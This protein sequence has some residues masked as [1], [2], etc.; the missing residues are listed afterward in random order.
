MHSRQLF[1]SAPLLWL[2]AVALLPSCAPQNSLCRHSEGLVRRAAKT[3]DPDSS[4]AMLIA[5]LSLD[6]NCGA[7][8]DKFEEKLAY[9]NERG[10]PEK[11]LAYTDSAVKYRWSTRKMHRFRGEMLVDL[12]KFKRAL[13]ELDTALQMRYPSLGF[14]QTGDWKYSD[15]PCIYMNRAMCKFFLE[16][17]NGAREDAAKAIDLDR[18][19]D[20]SLCNVTEK[21]RALRV[22]AA[23]ACTPLTKHLFRMALEDIDSLKAGPSHI[24]DRDEM[25]LVEGYALTFLEEYDQ[26]LAEIA[27]WPGEMKTP[28]YAMLSYLARFGSL[29]AR[30]EY[31]SLLTLADSADH[32]TSLSEDELKKSTLYEV[33]FSQGQFLKAAQVYGSLLDSTGPLK[34]LSKAFN[35][36][37]RALALSRTDSIAAARRLIDTAL[38]IDSLEPEVLLTGAEVCIAGKEYRRAQTLIDLVRRIDPDEDGADFTAALLWASQGRFDQ[39]RMY[40]DA[41]KSRGY[42]DLRRKLEHYPEL[43]DLRESFQSPASDTTGRPAHGENTYRNKK[44]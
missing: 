24:M 3:A 8:M 9:F 20:D 36:A 29:L 28:E 32:D 14:A 5:A 21:A 35:A 18:E 17:Y 25:R 31:D 12:K 7:A 38:N 37:S 34:P 10:E 27:R 39:A 30:Q 1:S 44:H 6:H 4:T 11:V 43:Q 41:A 22:V 42:R 13:H 40:L 23:M 33:Y 2:L 16:D 15:D 19:F 26:A